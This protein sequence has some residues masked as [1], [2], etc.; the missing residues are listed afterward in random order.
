MT[1]RISRLDWGLFL[2]LAMVW[3]S[4]YLFIKIGIESLSP[5]TLVACRLGIAGAVLGTVVA[6]ARE[7]LPR[8]RAT[9]AK[10][11]VMALLNVVIPFSLIA[12]GERYIDS[13]LAAVLQAI[14]P[15]FTLVLAALALDD[16]S[17]SLN[18]LVGLTVGFGGVVVLVSGSLGSPTGDEAWKG[19]LALVGSS[20]AYAAGNVFVRR[21]VR[22][23][24]P[25]IPAFFQVSIAFV[26]IAGLAVAFE[27][28][29]HLPTRP[30]AILAVTWLGV[31]GSA[32]AYLIYFRLV[33]RLGPTRLSL[34][35]YLMPVVGVSLGVSVLGETIDARIFLASALILG[36][37]A[38]VNL[39]LD[40]FLPSRRVRVNGPMPVPVP[41]PIK[42]GDEGGS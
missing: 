31:L 34:I 33:H 25:M 36:G 38:L 32:F 13:G 7:R 39:R 21:Q 23:L 26:V 17:I 10:L 1:T 35:T 28:P 2:I 42:P 27:S 3:G 12:W 4:S 40:R 5:L 11:G 37:V 6:V 30:E 22:G 15:L 24:R 20:L 8:D 14:T 29:I 41:V 9:Y 18:R 19:E 16:E